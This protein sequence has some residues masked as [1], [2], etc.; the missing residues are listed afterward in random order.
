ML[1]FQKGI[2]FYK[3]RNNIF[4]ASKFQLPIGSWFPF[5]SHALSRAFP[6]ALPHA[7]PHAVC[8]L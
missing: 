6:H 4:I 7:L 5:D 3:T 2:F 1:T 8:F